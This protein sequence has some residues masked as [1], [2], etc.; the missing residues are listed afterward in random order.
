L[1]PACVNTSFDSSSFTHLFTYLF[2]KSFA[3]AAATI[4]KITADRNVGTLPLLPYSTMVASA[5][6]WLTY[7][8]LLNESKIWSSNGIGLVLGAYYFYEFLQHCPKSSPT[9]PGRKEQHVQLVAAVLATTLIATQT[10]T[11]PAVWIGRVAVAFCVIL[12]ASP[13]AALQTVIQQK[14]ARSI[15]LPFTVASVANCFL[16][17][18]VGLF[19]MH[20]VNVYLPNLLGLSFGLA[21]VALKLHYGNG[22][23]GKRGSSGTVELPL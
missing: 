6:L 13:L 14:S 11:K 20:D 10:L 22:E 17:S 2:P 18:I 4:R 7:G 5:F 9:L 3:S 23:E 16:W 21:Q 8:I 15:P 1:C 12:F 19:D